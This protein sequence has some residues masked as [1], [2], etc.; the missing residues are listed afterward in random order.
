MIVKSMAWFVIYRDTPFARGML[1]ALML[2]MKAEG[3]DVAAMALPSGV[4]M[5][6]M[7][8]S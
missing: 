5:R 7:S 3:G 1:R 4:T 2:E 6:A 8:L